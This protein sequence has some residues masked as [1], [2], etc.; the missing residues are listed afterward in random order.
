M[1]SPPSSGSPC[2]VWKIPASQYLLWR[3]HET[4]TYSPCILQKSSQ[5]SM[6]VKNR[7]N[8]LSSASLRYLPAAS[9][10]EMFLQLHTGG[11]P[12]WC[13]SLHRWLTWWGGQRAEH[14]GRGSGGIKPFLLCL[15][16]LCFLSSVH[17]GIN[18]LSAWYF[19]ISALSVHSS[20]Q[21]LWMKPKSCSDFQHPLNELT[22]WSALSR[23]NRTWPQ[24]LTG[25]STASS[26][27]V[28]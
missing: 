22:I 18:T 16:L 28:G 14:R 2:A 20:N 4:K 21:C 26:Y 6:T 13:V 5:E 24:D 11:M 27:W 25:L 3:V 12:L 1:I 17:N 7:V 9:G 19:L 10:K 15:F 8:H 23:L